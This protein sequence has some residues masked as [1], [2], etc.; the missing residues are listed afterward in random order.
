LSLENENRNTFARSDY[1]TAIMF[2]LS[3]RS[4]F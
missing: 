4:R 1:D 2:G 3:F